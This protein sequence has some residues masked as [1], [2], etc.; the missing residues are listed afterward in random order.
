MP[1]GGDVYIDFV[2]A[3]A[4]TQQKPTVPRNLTG[5]EALGGVQDAD[6]NQLFLRNAGAMRVSDTT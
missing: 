3:V 4:Y 6:S 5:F 2:G 1:E